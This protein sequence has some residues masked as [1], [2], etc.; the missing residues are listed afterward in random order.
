MKK[1]GYLRTFVKID[2]KCI[3]RGARVVQSVDQGLDFNSGS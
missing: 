3:F 2:K 1:G